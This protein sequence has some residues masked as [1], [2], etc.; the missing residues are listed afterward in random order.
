MNMSKIDK[1]ELFNQVSQFLK[2]KGV[3]LQEGSY[4]RTIQKGCQ[5]LADTI[6]LSQ[7]AMERARSEVEQNLER[8]RQVIHEKTAPRKPP[9]TP[10]EAPGKATNVSAEVTAVKRTFSK[11]PRKSARKRSRTAGAKRTSK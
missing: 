10:E 6:N 1:D 3:E 11:R 5:L 2:S 9:V 8:A 4:A 7:Q